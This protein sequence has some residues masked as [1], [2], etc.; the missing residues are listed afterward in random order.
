MEVVFSVPLRTVRVRFYRDFQ[1]QER[2]RHR[3]EAVQPARAAHGSLSSSFEVKPSKRFSQFQKMEAEMKET[4]KVQSGNAAVCLNLD[5]LG[6]V[7]FFLINLNAIQE[8][9]VLF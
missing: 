7:I 5:Y 3:H 1:R 8:S 4:P 6:Y 9:I 2:I